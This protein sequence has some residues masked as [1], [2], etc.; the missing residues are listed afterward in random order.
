MKTR[1]GVVNSHKKKTTMMCTRKKGNKPDPA[2]FSRL[3]WPFLVIIL[4][5]GNLLASAQPVAA[6]PA[7][8][9]DAAGPDD[10][11]ANQKDLN[12]FCQSPGNDGGLSG[13]SS[14]DANLTWTWDDT[15]WT[16]NNTGDACALYDTDGDGKANFALCATVAGDPATQSSGS[17]RFYSCDDTKRLNCGSA[18]QIT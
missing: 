10:V 1:D 17:P 9:L 3:V 13:C 18:T 2:G 11:N 14:S 4:A 15:A 5:L 12:E 8:L 6:T 16:G 7:C